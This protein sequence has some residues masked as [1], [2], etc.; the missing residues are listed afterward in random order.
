MRTGLTRAEADALP[1]IARVAQ[2]NGTWTVYELGDALPPGLFGAPPDPNPVPLTVTRRQFYRALM[3]KGWFGAS[4]PSIDT[5]VDQLL[6]ALPE[7]PREVARVEWIES[8]VMTYTHPLLRQMWVQL[9]RTLPELEDVFR[10][11]DTFPA[12]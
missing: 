1:A 9:G 10:L 3:V 11:A 12:A 4:K 6:A 7:P 2:P 8:T 5:V